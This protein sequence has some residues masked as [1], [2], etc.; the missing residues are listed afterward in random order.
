MKKRLTNQGPGFFLYNLAF[1][2]AGFSL[3]TIG[4]HQA[5]F[6]SQ[7]YEFIRKTS[8]LCHIYVVNL[9]IAIVIISVS[10]FACCG[11]VGA[12]NTNCQ[13]CEN[14]QTTKT[15]ALLLGF[16]LVFQIGTLIGAIELQVWT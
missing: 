7:Y 5:L 3:L 1:C 16:I 13:S 11:S 12:P 8:A 9:V 14:S 15:Y 4:L 10:L 2:L 6:N